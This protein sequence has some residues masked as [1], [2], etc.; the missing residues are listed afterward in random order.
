MI[1]NCPVEHV[2]C[3]MCGSTARRIMP[4]FYIF[5]NIACHHVRCRDCG[6]IYV[7][8]RPQENY[9]N[10][11][12]AEEYFLGQGYVG[13][14]SADNGHARFAD[15]LELIAKTARKTE[16]LLE[17]GCADGYFLS[18]AA[19]RGWKVTG[20]ELSGNMAQYARDKRHLNVLTGTLSNAKFPERSFDCIYMGDVLEHLGS[21]KRTLIE[22]WRILV[23]G[24]VLVLDV[25]VFYNTYYSRISDAYLSV[26]KFVTRKGHM[27]KGPP[28]HLYEFTPKTLKHLLGFCGFDVIKTSQR[29]LMSI[30]PDRM[31]IFAWKRNGR[32]NE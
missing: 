6:L 14:L 5:R 18:L 27:M 22:C 28:R 4:R 12:Y 26:R 24:G 29:S 7:D 16:T 11:M 3:D 9:I 21:P 23:D 32:A 1:E 25:P 10:E 17:I 20:V 2:P 30:N 8:P 31:T 19:E 13:G 15:M